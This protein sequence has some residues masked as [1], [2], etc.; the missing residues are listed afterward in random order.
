MNLHS[1]TIHLNNLS[2]F[3]SVENIRSSN[4]VEFECELR[5]I[6]TYEATINSGM[7]TIT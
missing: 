6:S 7:I 3:E 5:H 4:T 1:T 2:N